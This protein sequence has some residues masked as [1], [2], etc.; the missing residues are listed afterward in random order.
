MTGT[1][2]RARKFRWATPDDFTALGE[3]MFDAVR[4]GPSPYSDS[5]RQAWVPE[6]RRGTEWN[7][8]LAQQD[9]I[10]AEDGAKIL[11]FMSLAPGG[12][13]DFAHIRPEARGGGLFRQLATRILE[14]A[15]SRGV[16][17][18]WVHASLMA[19]PAFAALGF[20]ATRTE[21]VEIGSERLER[22]EM[23]MIPGA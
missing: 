18:L 2:M 9:I 10:V 6:P 16:D 22:A 1:D 14:R 13:I 15:K 7:E 12:Y 4:N 3:V 23:E 20:T 17:R 19:Q 8:R 21:F 5:Q 11:G